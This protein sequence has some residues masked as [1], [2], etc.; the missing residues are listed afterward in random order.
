MG[1]WAGEGPQEGGEA[2]GGKVMSANLESVWEPPGR[3]QELRE[4][5]QVVFRGIRGPQGPL[6]TTILQQHHQNSQAWVRAASVATSGDSSGQN[7]DP[8]LGTGQGQR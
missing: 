3:Q 4:G 8:K 1:N 6:T 5:S 7:S 2:A